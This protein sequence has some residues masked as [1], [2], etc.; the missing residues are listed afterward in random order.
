MNT[1][2]NKVEYID[3]YTSNA[4]MED[5]IKKGL[6]QSRK[7]ITSKYFYDQRGSELF[8]M[9]TKE[10]EYYPTRAELEIFST[11][12]NEMSEAI[13]SVHTL[14][15]Y[16]SGSSRKIKAL[17]DSLHTMEE[18]LPIDISKEFLLQSCN[19]L[20][21]QF[22]NL[23]IKAICGDYTMPLLLPL[24]SGKK[25]VIFFPG[26]TI[27]NFEPED[28]K[29]FL[30]QS[31]DIL[32]EG[33][34]FLIG[35]DMKKDQAILEEAY[36]DRN[37]ITAE[38]NKNVLTRLNV[39]LGADFDVNQFK[40]IAFYNKDKGRIEMHLQSAIEQ[41]VRI[42]GEEYHFKKGERIHTE[43]SYKYSVSEFQQLSIQ[44]GFRPLKSW[45]DKQDM[46]SVHYLV[47]Q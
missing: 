46:F 1:L 6:S 41:T 44:C 38:F 4:N 15:E 35:V 7:Q 13:G 8:E 32:A 29:E 20:S 33:D 26:S 21:S 40:H 5:E 45:S 22:P 43:N 2:D 11:H 30:L 37:G 34:G 24:E 12:V 36:N 25:R 17:L 23:N 10:R 14:I 39:E 47:K 27:G 9:I 19:R 3:L 31:G 18:Y 16:G 42:R 28:A